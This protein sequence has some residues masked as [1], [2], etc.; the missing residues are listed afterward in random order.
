MQWTQR[1]AHAPAGMC[2]MY[3]RLRPGNSYF[4]TSSAIQCSMSTFSRLLFALSLI[5]LTLGC[6]SE[7]QTFSEAA[8]PVKT[9]VVG[10]G[11]EPFVRTFPGKV[12]AAKSVELAFQVPGLLIRLPVKEGQKIAKGEVIAQLRQDEFQARLK[13]IQGQLDQARA[14]LSALQ[15]GERPEERLRREAQLRAAEAKVANAKTEFD[16]YARLVKTSAVSRSEYELAETAYRVAQEDQKAALQLVEKGTGAR[17]EDIDAQIAQVRTTEGRLAEAN[18]QLRD[19]TLRAPYDGV[20]A[21]RS[22]DEGQTII[23]N[24]PVVT[25]QNLDEIDVV[26]DVPEAAIA[27]GIRSPAITNMIAE[28]SA[29]PGRQ[30]PVQ[31]KEVAQVADATT[32]TFPVRVVMRA[33]SGVTVLPGMTATIVATYQR[34]GTQGKRILVP[35]SAVYKQDTGDQVAWV[36]GPY[37]MISRRVVKMGAATG[38]DVEILAGL[39]PGDR[40]VVAG[41]PFLSE[42]MKVRDLGDALG[43]GQ[44]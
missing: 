34:P 24:K 5:F 19:S 27:A 10:A 11:N 18:I 8:R 40:V 4:V 23:A 25:F 7:K 42:G 20:V 35:I 15:L 13:S 14:T 3:L 38:G 32:Q 22:V 36:V 28:L 9:M 33:P 2:R 26:A 44:R 30:F 29:V 41:A 16:R 12:E 6:S 17:K 43:G 37:E 31:V 39:R 21:Q 1:I